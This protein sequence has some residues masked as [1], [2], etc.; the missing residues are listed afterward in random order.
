[1]LAERRR[2]RK[3]KETHVVV[4]TERERERERKCVTIATA[5]FL[6]AFDHVDKIEKKLCLSSFIMSFS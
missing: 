3:K 2:R 5:I 1:M 4:Q 6:N